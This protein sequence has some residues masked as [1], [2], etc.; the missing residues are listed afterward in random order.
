MQLQPF[1]NQ[2]QST[3]RKRA[4]EHRAGRDLDLGLFAGVLRVK[5][6]RRMVLE[7][8]LDHDSEEAADAGHGAILA[9]A[10]VEVGEAEGDPRD[11]AVDSRHLLGVVAGPDRALPAVELVAGGAQALFGAHPPQAGEECFAA[12]GDGEVRSRN[13]VAAY[14]AAIG[15]YSHGVNT[16]LLYTSDAADDLTR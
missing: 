1:A 3:R 11:L 4:S 8:H 7:V 10:S 16:C 5:I 15:A 14:A 6:R 12:L 9:V 13:P 2:P